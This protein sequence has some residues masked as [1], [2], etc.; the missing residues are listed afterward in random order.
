[1]TQAMP[2]VREWTPGKSAALWMNLAGLLLTGLALV[3]FALLYAVTHP[4]PGGAGFSITF[5]TGELVG[6]VLMVLGI[7]VGTVIHEL[8]H[9]V[10]IRT[11]GG[12][13]RYGAKLVSGV[14]P[15]FYT[16]CPGLKLS[17]RAFTYV[18]LL[19]G[20]VLALLPAL[21]IAFGPGGG[22]LVVPAGF[23][24]GGAIGDIVMTF[25]AWRTPKG[26]LVEDMAEG[27]RFFLPAERSAH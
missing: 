21:W 1:M 18:A 2:P 25:V 14:M 9:G 4:N 24:L 20:I 22:W 11:L 10:G 23:L 5:R 26:T 17:K 19:P 16:T 8:L 13:P 12:R 27:M 6:L 7:V 3:G 15:V